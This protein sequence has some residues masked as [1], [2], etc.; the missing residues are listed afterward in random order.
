M[1]LITLGTAAGLP[2]ATRF[3]T[4]SLLQTENGLYLIDAGA[5]AGALIIRKNLSLK[6]LR[7]VF[8]THMHE[9]HFGGLTGILKSRMRDPS[10]SQER[11]TEVWLPQQDAIEAFD[12][13]MKV[14]FPKENRDRVRYELIAPGL[15]FDDGFLK[16]TAIPN[17]HIVS[18]SYCFL[19]EAQ[20]RKM[21]CTGDLSGD[22]SDFPLEA[23]KEADLVLSEFT[24]FKPEHLL[25]KLL[26]IH[27]RKLIL[28]H[29]A[30]YR[31]GAFPAIAAALD[32]PAF[33]ANDGDE[34]E[35]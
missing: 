13:L 4:A 33:L 18:P 30:V 5:P 10:A 34:F 21:V 6:D 2:T 22:C 1:K 16:V 7:A 31:E 3:N 29:V 35:W 17:R 28:H 20:G 8:L 15:F 32:Y 24:H 23:A 19:I 25:P 12:Q 27:P 11:L 9:D 26:E 14:Q